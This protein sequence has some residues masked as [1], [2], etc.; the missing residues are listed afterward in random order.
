M[1]TF[2]TQ[3]IRLHLLLMACILYS[4]NSGAAVAT[5]T[6]SQSTSAYTAITGGT[7]IGTDTADEENFTNLNIGFTFYYN[8]LLRTTFG[9]NANGYL[10]LGTQ[11]NASH[12][13]ISGMANTNLVAALS[14]DIAAQTG[15]EIMYK[16]IGS[17]PNRTLVVQWKNYTS[18]NATGEALNFQIRLNETSNSISVN[19]GTFTITTTV[20]SAQ[21]GLKG[22]MSSDYNNRYARDTVNT[23]AT[24]TAGNANSRRMMVTSAFKPASGLTFTWTPP[25]APADPT[26]LTFTNVYVTSMNVN[27][28]DNSTDELNFLVYRSTDN[29]TYTLVSTVQTTSGAT[30]GTAYSYTASGLTSNML[31]YWKIYAVNNVPSAALAGSQ[32]TLTAVMCGTYLVG[33]TG[34][35]ATIREAVDSLIQYGISCSVVI[36]LQSTYNSNVDTFPIVIPDLACA[37]LKTLTL[38]PTAGATNVSIIGNDAQIFD[39]SGAQYFTIDGRAGG[40]GTAHNLTIRDSSATGTC[41]RFVNDAQYNNLRYLDLRGG[42]RGGTGNTGVVT[43]GSGTAAGGGNS[44]NSVT[45]C[46]FT[47]N[48]TAASIMLYSNAGGGASNDSNNVT[49]NT[50]HDWFSATGSNFGISLGTANAAWTISSNSFFMTATQNYSSSSTHAAISIATGSG[51]GGGSAGSGFTI[52]SNIIGGATSSG[53]G[54]WTVAGTGGPRF[55]GIAMNVDNGTF[56]NVQGNTIKNISLTTNA[57]GGGGGSTIF[58]G[59]TVSGGNVHIGTTIANTIGSTSANNSIVTIAATSGATTNGIAV[60]SGDTVAITGNV[61]GGINAND[62]AATVT[63]NLTGINCSNGVFTITN[64]YI[65]SNTQANN[66]TNAVSSGTGST[67]VTGIL[68]ANSVTAATITGNTIKNV[69][70]Q[71]G[72]TGTNIVR[73]INLGGGVNSVSN[74]VVEALVNSGPSVGVNGSASVIGIY[75]V[76]ADTGQ[77]VANNTIRNLRNTSTTGLVSVTGIYVNSSSNSTNYIRKNRIYGLGSS[78]NTSVATIN[79]IQLNGGGFSYENNFIAI[80]TDTS[81]NSYTR[82]HIYNGIL[83]TTTTANNFYYNSVNI[84]GTGVLNDTAN[85]FA[86]RRTGGGVDIIRNNIFANLRS[87][88]GAGGTHYSIAFG[89]DSNVVSGKNDLFGNGTGY[90]TGL[91]DTVDQTSLFSWFTATGVDS[92]SVA[93]NPNFT[94]NVNLHINNTNPSGIESKGYTIAG[95]TTDYDNQVRPGPAGSVNGGATAPDIGA[96]EFD[97]IP[98]SIDMGAYAIAKPATIGCHSSSDSVIVTIKNFSS[99]TINFATTNTV[100]H[101]SVTGPNPFTFGAVTVN[102]GTL[103]GGATRNVTIASNYNMSA[104]GTYVFNAYLVTAGDLS[105]TND[106]ISGVSISVAGG[107]ASPSHANICSGDPVT[108]NVTGNVNGGTVQWQ[109]SPNNTTWTNVV[110]ATTPS[111]ILNPSVTTY[112]RA[113]TCGTYNS[114]SDTIVVGSV[115]APTT[116]GSSRCGPG[117]DTLHAISA[118]PVYWFDSLSG[119]SIVDNG[120]S[121][122]ASVSGT[123]TFYAAANGNMSAQNTLNT[124]LLNNNRST[125]IMFPITALTNV[126]ITGFSGQTDTIGT[127]TWYV[128]FRRDNYINVPGANT[129]SAGWILIDSAANIQSAGPGLLTN[130]P[131]SMDILIPAGETYSF[132]ITVSDT[133]NLAYSAGTGFTPGTVNTSNSDLQLRD[134]QAGAN[135]NAQSAPRV[136]NGSVRYKTS[137]ISSRVAAT[138][139]VTPPTAINGVAAPT[140]VCLGDSVHLTASSTNTNYQYAWSGDSTLDLYTGNS[141]YAHPLNS[142]SYVLSA[143][144]AASGCNASDTVVVTVKSSPN[145]FATAT[146][147]SICMGDTVNLDSNIPL[148]FTLGGGGGGGQSNQNTAYP[149][150]YGNYKFGARHQVL[151]RASEL[152]NTGMQAGWINSLTFQVNDTAGAGALVNFTIR[153]GATSVTVL[154]SN[155]QTTPMTTVFT[156]ASYSPLQGLN[157]HA[158]S[159]PFHWDGTSNI[160][161]QTCFNNASST[162]NARMRYS[163]TSYVSCAVYAQN[164][165]N[166]CSQTKADTLFNRRPYMRLGIRNQYTYAWSSTQTLS[167]TTISDPYSVPLA[168]ADYMITVTDTISGCVAHDTVTNVAD[169]APVVNLGSDT[170]VCGGILLDA[171]HP[172]DDYLWNDSSDN[173]NLSVDTTGMYFVTVTHLGSCTGTDS[174]NVVVNVVP[175][176]SLTLPDDT[177]CTFDG[178]LALSGG[179]P[180]GGTFGGSGVTGTNF[181]PLAVTP[182]LVVL[183]YSY[184]DVG[185]GCSN[186]ATDDIF[187]D[188]CNGIKTS[189]A[190]GRISVYPNPSSGLTTVDLTGMSGRCSVVLISPDSKLISRW[191]IE[192]GSSKVIDLDNLAEGIYYLRINNPDESFVI[193]VVKQ[194]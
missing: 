179:T 111:V 15:A 20:D 182:G 117:L 171:G 178:I 39:L 60:S 98:V 121:F 150:P 103:A 13:A 105:N 83:K 34:H 70:N 131:I 141:V 126:N 84:S 55:N 19:Y 89:N 192:G 134:G 49:S 67:T 177:M 36:E 42:A 162:L 59:I 23:W 58:N 26:T 17:A 71:S 169:A 139:T 29:V 80:G 3:I 91:L 112:Y 85:T 170:T 90:K 157:T 6:F 62:S 61:V 175:A 106:S 146:P 56:S 138:I 142:T 102:S 133:P 1:K 108:L 153:I 14:Y 158:F 152:I 53:T 79:G 156:S 115:S 99:V 110:S 164:N 166:N 87:N 188:P 54:T 22:A 194:D 4:I 163:T 176:V 63:T 118:N 191:Q 78:A 28:I 114:T 96:D 137:C 116:T 160:L 183:T 154:D 159:T 44:H 50:F 122:I 82:A 184:T 32:S 46:D 181:D 132:Y 65:G 51:G 136:F 94:S 10:V 31:Y 57:G 69:S 135:F 168:T 180:A 27:W 148:S 8:G 185:N 73:G 37:A 9:V 16:T 125:G 38:R 109:S 11:G 88:T 77:V 165:A 151:I 43:F 107:T 193:P 21:V 81:A 172:G 45:F 104:V 74:N 124:V 128:Y 113:V 41:I 120:T 97:G 66:M 129:S 30:T 64:N 75:E 155:F 92:N 33:P 18:V 48:D 143:S 93:V 12:G 145:L 35:F 25:A 140:A 95:I 72:G 2:T 147:D 127:S 68:L 47:K 174:I 123:Q 86:F 52:N 149:A 173:Q 130:I 144:D 100:V 186:V 5:Y 187:V 76:S 189:I 161:I 40:T 190:D 7:V 101:V 167:S 119:G 24:S